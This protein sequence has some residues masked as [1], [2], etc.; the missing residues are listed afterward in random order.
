MFNQLEIV[1]IITSSLFILA[2]AVSFFIGRK[3]NRK[4]LRK[5]NAFYPIK[6]L[7]IAQRT[8]SLQKY[9][10]ELTEECAQFIFAQGW[11]SY[12]KYKSI[13]SQD[14]ERVCIQNSKKIPKNCDWQ[15]ASCACI[16]GWYPFSSFYLFRQYLQQKLTQEGKSCVQ[17]ILQEHKGPAYKA[18]L[19]QGEGSQRELALV[20]T[21]AFF[22]SISRLEDLEQYPKALDF[23]MDSY[24]QKKAS[25]SA[26]QLLGRFMEQN[27][28]RIY[29]LL[30]ERCAK[31][32]SKELARIY[33]EEFF[34]RIASLQQLQSFPQ[35]LPFLLQGYIHNTAGASGKTLV[36]K[37]LKNHSKELYSNMFSY[38]YNNKDK[39]FALQMIQEYPH[40]P[41]EVKIGIL[42]CRQGNRYVDASIQKLKELGNE[43]PA[44]AKEDEW[45][46]LFKG[47]S[48]LLGS[49]IKPPASLMD[50]K[51]TKKLLEFHRDNANSSGDMLKVLD[52]E[53]ILETLEQAEK[54][55]K[56]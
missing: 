8:P 29:D 13:N 51:K 21:D 3:I 39:E 23:L 18:L 20:Y 32:D 36:N 12:E 19:S 16:Q 17:K 37:L 56:F 31:K 41:K 27:N 24:S 40:L 52:I 33:K 26:L 34:T 14:I 2:L 30:V 11:K 49:E 6:L 28:V 5:R 50:L 46:L 9:I 4:E 1:L 44:A 35:A 45:T 10:S 43:E 53:K 48:Q 22:D 15:S 25:L 42:S 55:K 38:L 47:I 7:N 54:E